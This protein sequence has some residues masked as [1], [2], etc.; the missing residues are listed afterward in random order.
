MSRSQ[1]RRVEMQRSQSHNP[2]YDEVDPY[3][4]QYDYGGYR[5]ANS[6]SAPPESQVYTD[7][8]E[9]YQP[10]FQGYGTYDPYAGEQEEPQ[11]YEDE[12]PRRYAQQKGAYGAAAPS[13]RQYPAQEAY[14]PPLSQQPR[15][16]TYPPRNQRYKNARVPPLQ[17]DWTSFQAKATRFHGYLSNLQKKRDDLQS[18]VNAFQDNL[19]KIDNL[20]AI[21]A[22]LKPANPDGATERTL[23]KIK[24]SFSTSSKIKVVKVEKLHK[25][26]IELEGRENKHREI[27]KGIPDT[28]KELVRLNGLLGILEPYNEVSVRLV[29]AVRR[30][31]MGDVIEDAYN[32]PDDGYQEQYD[33]GFEEDIIDVYSGS[34]Y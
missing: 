18:K 23:R 8:N 29:S 33:T 31:E 20:K 7:K 21:Q 30:S 3:S 26:E 32:R 17:R 13:Q 25:V 28:R 10:G 2:V 12:E 34:R 24:A 22:D 9:Y 14:Q 4:A 11:S 19:N 16:N 15:S 27:S 5:A 6:K 1:S